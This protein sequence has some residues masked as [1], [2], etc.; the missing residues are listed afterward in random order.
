[1]DGDANSSLCSILFLPDFTQDKLWRYHKGTS[2]RKCLKP[3]LTS[4]TAEPG[5][6]LYLKTRAWHP[7][8]EFPPNF[9]LHAI[10][11]TPILV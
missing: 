7:H 9:P 5:F 4:G 10:S 8:V 3:V 2:G 6:P 1:M 11:H